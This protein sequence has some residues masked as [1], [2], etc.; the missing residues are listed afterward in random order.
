MCCPYH[1][2]SSSLM[3][4]IISNFNFQS[5]LN[6]VVSCKRQ[7]W[8][9]SN[10][11]SRGFSYSKL[12]SRSTSTFILQSASCTAVTELN[13]PYFGLVVCPD[14]VLIVGASAAI[15]FFSPFDFLWTWIFP[16]QYWPNPIIHNNCKEF[17]LPPCCFYTKYE[18]IF[19][20]RVSWPLKVESNC[21][22]FGAQHTSCDVGTFEW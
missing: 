19:W 9:W 3:T 2:P 1:A 10:R 16:H 7:S 6:S 5:A 20:P 11:L 18:R 17:L 13:E 22:L 14:S 21:E 12:Q 4:N 15:T 8:I